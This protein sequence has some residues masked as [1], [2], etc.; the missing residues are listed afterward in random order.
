MTTYVSESLRAFVAERADSKCEYCQLP[1]TARLFRFTVDHIIA[2]K[3]GGPTVESNL[4]LACL[5]C[6]LHKG[7]DIASLDPITDELTRL[8]NPREQRWEDHFEL[9]VEIGEVRGKTPP[10][11]ATARLL[12]MNDPERVEDRLRLIELGE[13]TV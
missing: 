5:T 3:H 11:R 6:N 13:L 9:D 7:S 10:G 8:Y 2:I 1:Q 12:Q 4:A